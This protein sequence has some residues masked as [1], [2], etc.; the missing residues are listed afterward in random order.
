MYS[1]KFPEPNQ[2]KC[3]TI[4]I[5]HNPSVKTWESG[6][7]FANPTNR[8]WSLLEESG[9]TDANDSRLDDALVAQK[10]IGFC[11]VIETP[12][13]DANDIK[14]ADFRAATPEFM[15]R[16]E[17]YAHSIEDSLQRVCFVGKRQWKLLFQ[18]SLPKCQHGLQDPHLRPQ[19]WPDLLREVEVWVLPSPSGRAVLTKQERVSQYIV[20]A[21]EI[22]RSETE[23]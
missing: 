19:S 12:G 22:R 23:W 3:H 11:D 4:F 16:I 18:P 8:F 7:F 13:N 15:A 14:N 20:L 10:G 17:K 9:I 6:H 1:A 21:K 5:G 2:K